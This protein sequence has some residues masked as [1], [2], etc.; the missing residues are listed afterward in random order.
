VG[1]MATNTD[2]LLRNELGEHS[3]SVIKPIMVLHGWNRC[4]CKDAAKLYY[5]PVMNT[6]SESRGHV[7]RF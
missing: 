7:E 4:G 2:K 3:Y 1:V 5:P 6:T